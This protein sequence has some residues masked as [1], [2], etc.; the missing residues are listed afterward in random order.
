MQPFSF[1][2]LRTYVHGIAVLRIRSTGQLACGSMHHSCVPANVL[3]RQACTMHASQNLN[4]LMFS[5]MPRA[6]AYTY[7]RTCMASHCQGIVR[8]L[9]YVRT[10]GG[11][12]EF[13]NVT[14]VC[15]RHCLDR[16]ARASCTALPIDTHRASAGLHALRK[17]AEISIRSYYLEQW[18]A[19]QWGTYVGWPP[20]TVQAR[21]NFKFPA[22]DLASRTIC[23]GHHYVGC[24]ASIG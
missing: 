1:P 11:P 6:L 4:K 15:Y 14:Y 8:R 13:P 17:L 5:T 19:L 10:C 16:L 9:A 24:W 23:T 3:R 2:Y 22:L 7:V 12:A 20:R 18:L 21:Q